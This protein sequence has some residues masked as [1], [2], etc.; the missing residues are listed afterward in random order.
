MYE[1]SRAWA[2]PSFADFDFLAFGR[3]SDILV[4]SFSF[5]FFYTPFC[6]PSLSSHRAS[7]VQSFSVF[8]FLIWLCSR[9][10]EGMV[11]GDKTF[12]SIRFGLDFLISKKECGN[13]ATL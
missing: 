6:S 10:R 12:G 4:D 5:C 1:L 11:D 7:L 8:G 9:K 2:V 13:T 3:T